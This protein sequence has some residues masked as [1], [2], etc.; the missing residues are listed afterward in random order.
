[1]RRNSRSLNECFIHCK[2]GKIRILIRD[3]T[4]ANKDPKKQIKIKVY[5]KLYIVYNNTKF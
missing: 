2:L 5:L 3:G 1:M 4:A